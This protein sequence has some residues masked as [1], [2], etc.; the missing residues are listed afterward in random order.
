[1]AFAP[2][3]GQE[4]LHWSVKRSLYQLRWLPEGAAQH[5]FQWRLDAKSDQWIGPIGHL[6]GAHWQHQQGAQALAWWAN[7][8]Q[9][10]DGHSAN[11]HSKGPR[12]DVQFPIVLPHE[13]IS[14]VDQHHPAWFPFVVHWSTQCARHATQ[15]VWFRGTVE[16]RQDPRLLEHP[17]K[18]TPR[19]KRNYVPL[20]LHDGAVPVIKVGK[21]GSTW[22]DVYSTFGLLGIGASRELKLYMFCIFTSSDVQEGR[23]T[24]ETI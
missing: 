12:W 14:Q 18:S 22:M 24:M 16:T 13:V 2:E 9:G 21:V 4:E 11:G 3:L 17:L 20:S 19:L 15:L 8:T 6:G 10:N 7:L 5:S 23:N 1:M